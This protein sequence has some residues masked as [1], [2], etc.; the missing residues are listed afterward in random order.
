MIRVYRR[1]DNENTAY[2]TGWLC[3]YCKR[4]DSYE[5]PKPHGP[6]ENQAGNE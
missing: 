3:P 2:Q 1:E 6:K 4:S 5:V